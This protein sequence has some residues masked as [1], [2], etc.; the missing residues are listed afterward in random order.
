VK[1]EEDFLFNKKKIVCVVHVLMLEH[2]SFVC[3]ELGSQ[4]KSLA[5]FSAVDPRDLTQGTRKIGSVFVCFVRK[6]RVKT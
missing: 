3:Q 6:Q 2:G 1:Y 4:A 5:N